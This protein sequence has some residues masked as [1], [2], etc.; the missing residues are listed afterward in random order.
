[1]PAAKGS[2]CTPLGP[3][4]KD[5]PKKRRVGEERGHLENARRVASKGSRD[6]IRN[7]KVT[8]ERT[9]NTWW[10]YIL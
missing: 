8:K 9:N 2:A 5:F 10:T 3:K 6:Q 7:K 1:M 4:F